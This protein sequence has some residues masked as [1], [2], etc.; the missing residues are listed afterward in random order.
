MRTGIARHLSWLL[1]M[2]ASSGCF[3]PWVMDRAAGVE[4]AGC[5][6]PP[7]ARVTIEHL[8]ILAS[9]D[10]TLDARVESPEGVMVRGQPSGAFRARARVALERALRLAMMDPGSSG[11]I[12]LSGLDD[13]GC[14]PR[15][16]RTEVVVAA[17]RWIRYGGRSSC[18][19]SDEDVL[20]WVPPSSVTVSEAQRDTV[21]A[22]FRLS[23]AWSAA[24]DSVSVRLAPDERSR[25]ERVPP[26]PAYYALV[27]LTA[28]ADLIGL[29]AAKTF[30]F[31]VDTLLRVIYL[32]FVPLGAA[33][34]VIAPAAIPPRTS[35]AGA[36]LGGTDLSSRTL[37]G[38]YRCV[39]LAGAQL[40][41]ATA[42]AGLDLTDADMFRAN[43]SHADLRNASGL[44]QAQLDA[45]CGDSETLV[46]AG[47]KPPGPCG[48]PV[49]GSH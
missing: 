15:V 49:Q 30:V 3:T 12:T 34:A 24:T 7:G 40:Y 43:L 38:S 42:R 16:V 8:A 26:M 48:P 9:G 17:D 46:P 20:V 32:A 39:R 31:S 6:I 5:G 36:N 23:P 11:E 44:T 27:P 22:K 47:L 41:G 29:G 13:S 19:E 37:S 25:L 1:I 2:L 18:E 10:L 21:A 4:Y 45:A 35:S 14:R 33:E 28:V